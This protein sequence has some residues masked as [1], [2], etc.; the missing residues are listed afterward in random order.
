M[1]Q[2]LLETPLL[3]F[4]HPAIQKL[5]L[6][7]KWNDLG[8]KEKIFHIYNFVRDSIFFG[9]NWDDAI[10]ASQVLADGYGQCNTK[11]ILFM[12]LLRGVGIPCRIHGFTIDKRLQKGAITGL[13]YQLSP[14]EIVHS[15]VEVSYNGSWLNIEGFIL[16]KPYLSKLQQKFR[17][18]KS[19]FCGYGVATKDFQNPPID[20][21]ENDTYIQSEGIVRDFGIFDDPDNLFGKH[22]QD[23]GKLK[24]IL[25]QNVVRHI[26]NHNIR[27]IRE[28]K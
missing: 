22:R 14:E 17:Q 23:I 4:R 13:I 2:Y 26:M 1:N 7:R 10:P 19:S 25:Y 9:Y 6:D 8:G 5:I 24:K 16:D 18:S 20:W 15:W 12:A 3:D 28:C 21:N 27:K 11:G